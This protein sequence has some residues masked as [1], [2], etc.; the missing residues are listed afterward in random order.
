[1]LYGSG[2]IIFATDSIP[3]GSFIRSSISNMSS[4]GSIINNS[5]E[6]KGTNDL[7]KQRGTLE[8]SSA[9]DYNNSEVLAFREGIKFKYINLPAGRIPTQEELEIAKTYGLKF[10]KTQALDKT[11]KNPK[12]INSIFL[13]KNNEVGKNKE[14]QRLIELKN[15]LVSNNPQKKIAIFTDSHA[16]FEPTLAIL[17]DARKNGITEIYSLGDNIGTGPNPKE[18]L[19][20]LDEYNVKSLKGN[21][22]LYATVGVDDFKLHLNFGSQLQEAKRNSEWTRDKLTKDQL[23]KIKKDPESRIIEV[24]GKKILLSHYTRDYN[25]DKMK[26]VPDGISDVFQGHLHFKNQS[27][28]GITTLNSAGFGDKAYYIILTELSD[29]GYTIEEKTVEYDKDS[30]YYDIE[31]SNMDIDDKSKVEGWVGV[32]K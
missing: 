31:E 6:D 28:D 20:L 8:T 1:M 22:E 7:R 18:V 21:H 4:N 30:S 12:S 2:R 13:E 11:I 25:S 5:Y 10:V 3:S 19:E 24:G 15:K 16:L 9:P 29:G 27:S 14:I 23:S 32:H 26:L 17:E